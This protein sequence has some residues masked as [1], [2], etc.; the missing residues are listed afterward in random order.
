M[1]SYSCSDMSLDFQITLYYNAVRRD[2]RSLTLSLIPYILQQILWVMI[3][4]ELLPLVPPIV[5]QRAAGLILLKISH[6]FS[7]YT[8]WSLPFKLRVK[9]S[10]DNGL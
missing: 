1:R 9:V 10:C 5:F 8:L 3:K 2:D 4:S 7:N 6:P